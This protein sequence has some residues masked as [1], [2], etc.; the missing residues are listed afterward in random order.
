MRLPPS[1]LPS[2]TIS[3]SVRQNP[4]EGQGESSFTTTSTGEGTCAVA[5]SHQEFSSRGFFKARDELIM[6]ALGSYFGVQDSTDDANIVSDGIDADGQMGVLEI[7]AW[8]ELEQEDQFHSSAGAVNSVRPFTLVAAPQGSDEARM[9]PT[10]PVVKSIHI[11]TSSAM[12]YLE[13]TRKAC[14]GMMDKAVP[15]CAG[16][17]GIERIE[18]FITSVRAD[19]HRRVH[20]D[21]AKSSSD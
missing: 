13:D 12:K 18:A 15:G 16:K 9:K 4:Q 7:A 11:G 10:V 2:P 5:T 3:A 19:E 20:L 8:Q 6:A 14:Y 17:E 1:P 21:L